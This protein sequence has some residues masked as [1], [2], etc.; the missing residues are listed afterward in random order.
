MKL[1][2]YFYG[3][4]DKLDNFPGSRDYIS[5]YKTFKDFMNNEVHKELKSMVMLKDNLTIYLNDHSK[6]H[7]EMVITKIS[8]MLWDDEGNVVEKISPFECFLLLSA[9]QIHDAGHIVGGRKDHEKN[10]NEYLEQYN[11]NIVGSADC[12][13]IISIS[14]A[15]SGKDD[16]I[17]KLQRETRIS[18]YKIRP[19]FLAA[20]LRIGDELADESSRASKYLFN[21]NEIIE[22]SRLFHAYSLCLESF[23]PNVD[24]QQVEMKFNL[25]KKVG[26]KVVD[27]YL[28]DEIYERTMKT[29][30]EC[31]YYNRFV[32]DTL[33]LRS[34]SVLIEFYEAKAYEPY[35][36]PISF[37]LEEKGY[38]Q[39]EENDIFKLCKS[40]LHRNGNEL[41]GEFV[42]NLIENSKEA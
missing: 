12:R 11:D 29:F 20:L 36:P 8:M 32:P 39:I 30:R 25:S 5:A 7:V 18:T 35:L 1:E 31:L 15:H 19:R 42:K 38:P 10:A 14:K 13:T 4:A 3:F 41:R 22:G 23:V 9:I 26:D 34:V 40:E 37:R 16:P 2:E 27:T 33:R 21:K 28:L 6:D 24:S 17:G